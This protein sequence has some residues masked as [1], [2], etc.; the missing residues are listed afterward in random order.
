MTRDEVM[1]LTND[2][3]QVK[4]AAL[5]GWTEIER[6]LIG[7]D[8]ACGWV[9]L[10][11]D[12]QS[13]VEFIPDYLNDIAAAWELRAFCISQGWWVETRG[14]EPQDECTIWTDKEQNHPSQFT[15]E[16]GMAD[17]IT[18]AFVIAMEAE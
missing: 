14:H 1:A 18:V 15:G 13:V 11:P 3:L 16:D 9:G 8:M 2:E 17:A 12:D 10:M 7:K 5:M 6:N 4:A